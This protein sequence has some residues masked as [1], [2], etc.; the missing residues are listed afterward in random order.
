MSVAAAAA[1]AEAVDGAA[2][3]NLWERIA[4]RYEVFV[5]V[6]IPLQS[7]TSCCS[8]HDRTSEE[9]LGPSLQPLF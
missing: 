5:V 7:L 2:R 9:V 3:Q 6:G 4:V 1:A 8:W